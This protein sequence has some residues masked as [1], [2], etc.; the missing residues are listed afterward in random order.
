MRSRFACGA[1]LIAAT[2][3]AAIV[4]C[5]GSDFPTAQVS[6]KV[7]HQGQGVPNAG[8]TFAPEPAEGGYSGKSA[9][10]TTD[11]SG[12][13]TLSTYQPGDGAVVGK[14]RVYV[15][16]ADELQFKLPGAAPEGLSLD[17]KPGD[18]HFEI[19]LK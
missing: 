15:H 7:V 11:A 16:S 12:S 9:S 1:R 4:G 2:L 8:V 5:G 19:E 14:H 17:V 10:G 3:A 6:G 18:N 13:F